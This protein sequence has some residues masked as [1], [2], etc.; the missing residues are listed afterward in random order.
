MSAEA[1]MNLT[2]KKVRRGS[3]V[4]TDRF[5]TF[6]GLMFCRYRHVKIDQKRFGKENV[7]IKGLRETDA[8]RLP[9]G[10]ILGPFRASV[11]GCSF[12]GHNFQ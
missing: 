10:I 7:Y 2:V 8:D 12:L 3:I 9:I 1:I 5:R 4:Y 11:L 6:D